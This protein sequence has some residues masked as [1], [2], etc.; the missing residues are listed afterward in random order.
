LKIRELAL[1]EVHTATW[2]TKL[3][4]IAAMMKRHGVGVVPLTLDGKLVGMITD[5]DIAI[6]CTAAGM[7]PQQCRAKEFMTAEPVSVS[8]DADIEE[9][10]R[11]MGSAQLHRLPV[12]DDGRLVGIISIGDIAVNLSNNDLLVETLRKIST[13]S[14]AT[15]S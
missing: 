4:E 13:P 8:V 2:D 3:S 1:K 14:S 15:A 12:V 10:A 6:G 7:P 11:V 9:A 5:R